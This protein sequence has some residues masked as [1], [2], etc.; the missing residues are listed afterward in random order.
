[1][2]P[3]TR[4]MKKTTPKHIIIKLLKTSDKE[5]ILKQLKGGKRHIMHR[6]SKI[7]MTEKMQDRRQ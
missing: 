7:S 3:K 4:H 6:D 2:K 1:M 5:N